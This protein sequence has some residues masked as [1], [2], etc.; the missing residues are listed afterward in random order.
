MITPRDV[1]RAKRLM[2]LGMAILV[3]GG[4]VLLVLVIARGSQNLALTGGLVSWAVG[5]GVAIY[6]PGMGVI[7]K[8]ESALNA[9]KM[10]D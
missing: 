2:N 5:S 7:C 3:L 6:A 9:G 4:A 8:F 1:V 10:G